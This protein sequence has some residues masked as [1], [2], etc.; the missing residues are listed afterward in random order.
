MARS[1]GVVKLAYVIWICMVVVMVPNAS[2]AAEAESSCK[3]INASL[4]P[5]LEYVKGSGGILPP[6]AC[7][8]GVKFLFSGAKT[9]S[10]RQTICKCLQETTR[11]IND[12]K[13]NLV[14]GL[15]VICGVKIPF[16]I[17][18]SLNCSK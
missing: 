2:L 12:I 1:G 4:Q 6:A 13:E 11:Q 16:P 18:G 14:S 10:D 9:T 3:E 7:R 15:L 5:C 17:T 8:D